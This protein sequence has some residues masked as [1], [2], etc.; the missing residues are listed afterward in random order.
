MTT[1]DASPAEE[2]GHQT[3]PMTTR[4]RYPPTQAPVGTAA[5]LPIL[6]S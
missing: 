4:L 1:R 2:S 6:A 5:V 3:S